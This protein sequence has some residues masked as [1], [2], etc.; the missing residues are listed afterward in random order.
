M[1][2]ISV[3]WTVQDMWLEIEHTGDLS[4]DEMQEIKNEWF[5]KNVTCFE[6]FPAQ[7]ELINNGN[8]RHL[9]RWPNMADMC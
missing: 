5:G 7:C 8:Y 3:N 4:W 1:S 9:H 2:V 6:M